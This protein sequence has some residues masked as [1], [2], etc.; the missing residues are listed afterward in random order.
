MTA[1]DYLDRFEA[2]FKEGNREGTL[3]SAEGIRIDSVVAEGEDVVIR[4]SYL[5]RPECR[6]AYFVEGLLAG[7]APSEQPEVDA[8]DLEV[9]FDEDVQPGYLAYTPCA[10]GETMWFECDTIGPVNGRPGGGG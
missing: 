6:F 3:R 8:W 10:P 4:F 2:Q 9:V 1:A 7:G 5:R